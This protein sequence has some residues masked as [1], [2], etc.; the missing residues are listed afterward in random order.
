MISVSMLRQPH[1]QG[2]TGYQRVMPAQMQGDG[3][4]ELCFD[5][6]GFFLRQLQSFDFEVRFKTGWFGDVGFASHPFVKMSHPFSNST[7]LACSDESIHNQVRRG[8]ARIYSR[9][10]GALFLVSVQ[11]ILGRFHGILSTHHPATSG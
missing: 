10:A 3:S 11:G 1:C 4:Y 2:L 8:Y 7:L 9:I 5:P 6:M